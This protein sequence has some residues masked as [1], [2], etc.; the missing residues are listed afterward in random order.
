MTN[1]IDPGTRTADARPANCFAAWEFFVAVAMADRLSA[2]L[3]ECVTRGARRA[4]S[5]L[6]AP[7]SLPYSD[8]RTRNYRGFGLCSTESSGVPMA[9]PADRWRGGS[10]VYRDC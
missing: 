3:T 5:S 6:S 4:T 9:R 10:R 1:S 8:L 7:T 2:L